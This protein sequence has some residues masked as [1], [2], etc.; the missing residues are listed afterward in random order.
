M[1]HSTIK[2]VPKRN[3]NPN[4]NTDLAPRRKRAL[5][6]LA[7]SSSVPSMQTPPAML[8]RC[9][10][11]CVMKQKTKFV[12]KHERMKDIPET[13]ASPAFSTMRIPWTLNSV[14]K[15]G[16]HPLTQKKASSRIPIMEIALQAWVRRDGLGKGCCHAVP[17]LFST[18][19]F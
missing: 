16:I 10:C 5:L 15:R 18:F 4:H 2:M 13:K 17:L 19:F 7:G 14:M 12:K 8:F 3:S 6:L 11:G 9:C 1:V